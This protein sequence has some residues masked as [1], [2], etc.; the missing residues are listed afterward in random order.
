MFATSSQ[1]GNEPTSGYF[2]GNSFS[3]F[4]LRFLPPFMW[5]RAEVEKAFPTGSTE[6]E[7]I[8]KSLEHS[9]SMF[10]YYGRHI[11]H[12]K[13][14]ENLLSEITNRDAYVIDTNSARKDEMIKH[15]SKAFIIAAA[16]SRELQYPKKLIFDENLCKLG[17]IFQ[18]GPLIT[19]GRV[20]IDRIDEP[21]RYLFDMKTFDDA[22]NCESELF[23]WGKRQ[24]LYNNTIE[25]DE[26]LT[27]LMALLLPTA[28]DNSKFLMSSKACDLP[29]L[30]ALQHIVDKLV[31]EVKE[32]LP[33]CRLNLNKSV[34]AARKSYEV[35]L[36]KDKVTRADFDNPNYENVF[37]DMH[38]LGIAIYLGAKILTEDVGLKKMA[39][40]AGIKCCRFPEA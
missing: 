1:Q 21:F 4:T 25:K 9:F 26:I 19:L 7:R 3:H 35:M 39:Q 10:D 13:E 15:C 16:L 17:N 28:G 14:K 23:L 2:E 30:D 18:V 22:F 20:L 27:D 33:R 6:R 31:S 37:G 5:S 11:P 40:P 8:I 29:R 12:I 36:L 34:V 38:V 32:L 24:H